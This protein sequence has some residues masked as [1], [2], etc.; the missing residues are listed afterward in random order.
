MHS[1]A[2]THKLIIFSDDWGRHPSSCQHLARR[3]VVDH[4]ILWVNTIGMRSPTLSR[5]DM[6]KAWRK[7]SSWL[8]PKTKPEASTADEQ[9]HDASGDVPHN[10]RVINPR[11]W[12]GFRA[13]WQK[14]LNAKLLA[15]AVHEALGPRQTGEKRTVITTLPITADLIGKLDVDH[16]LYYCVDDFSVWPGLDATVMCEME[17][18]QVLK[19]DQIVCVSETLSKRLLDLGRS[20]E[21]LTHGIDLNH[22]QPSYSAG[23]SQSDAAKV[24]S[25]PGAQNRFFG[26]ISGPILL[27]W[28]LID[29]RL[30]MAWCRALCDANLGQLVMVGPQQSP[31]ESLATLKG[32]TIWGPARY[33]DLPA[34]AQEADVLLMP[35]ADLP[36]TRAM[37]PLKFKEYLATGKPVVARAL[38]GITDWADASDMVTDQTAFVAK[39][40]ERLSYGLPTQQ[41][42][43]RQR[44]SEETWDH[45]ARQLAQM[46]D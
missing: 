16:W 6:G 15:Q 46:L 38:P 45:K 18:Q 24:Q 25:G 28:G 37:Q 14:K 41:A 36:V 17:A 10:M 31:D 33:S 19:V 1:T 35:Y 11:M 4:P 43:A 22:W 7:I 9:P 32:V 8:K 39:V 40:K 20:A 3:L 29:T 42:I 13:G 26:D 23:T 44:L 5:E 30:D 34:M 12:P 2:V 27:F 21:M